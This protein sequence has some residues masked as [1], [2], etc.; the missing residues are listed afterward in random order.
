MHTIDIVLDFCI[1]SAILFI[2]KFL[3]TRIR[4]LQRLHIPSALLAGFLALAIGPY[5]LNWLHFT[6][7]ASGYATILIAVLFATLFLGSKKEI[8]VKSILHSV[9]DTFLVNYSAET[10]QFAFFLLIGAIVLANFFPD[11]HR[12]FALMLPAGFIGG[13]GTAAA[14]GSAFAETGWEE[15]TSIGQTFATIGL[16]FGIIVGVVYINIGV[17]KGYTRVVHSSGELI[18]EEKTGLLE[19]NERPSFGQETVSSMS[20]DPL[21]WHLILVLISVG[22]AYGM[23]SILKKVLPQVSFPIYG[24]SLIISLAVQSILHVLKL[25]NYVD[26]K[27]ITHIGS[28]AT[29]FLVAFGVATININVVLAY[30]LPILILTILGAAMVTFFLF[31]VSPKLFHNY[32]F[33]RGIYIFGMSTGVMS[34]GVIL[35]RII[36]PNFET[37]VLEDFGLAWVLMTFVDLLLVSLAPIMVTQGL[38]LITGLVLLASVLLALGLCAK[39]YGIH[40]SKTSLREDEK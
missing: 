7:E 12:G 26:K 4:V 11:I 31:V 28:S 2:A 5:G 34:T 16:L 25:D 22:G 38:D 15:A 32:W 18:H 36:D 17:R 10:S 39:N 19:E 27:I 40:K 21:S 3:R 6:S 8:R 37:G 33:E 24:L 35:L 20:I 1:M 23:N 9:G 13:H 29:D 14:I 30:W